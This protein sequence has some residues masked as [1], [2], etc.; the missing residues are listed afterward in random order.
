MSRLGFSLTTKKIYHS[1]QRCFIAVSQPL[2][3]IKATS[4][5]LLRIFSAYPTILGLY[6]S[7]WLGLLAC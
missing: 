5:S 1:Y 7:Y 2:L 4:E 3:D 6:R